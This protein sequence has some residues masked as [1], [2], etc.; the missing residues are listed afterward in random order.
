MKKIPA[1]LMLCMAV[2]SICYAAATSETL[3][4]RARPVSWYGKTAAGVVTAVKVEDDGTVVTSGGSGESV[5]T[6][7]ND[8][9]YLDGDVTITGVFEAV[10]LDVSGE[11]TFDSNVTVAAL[12]ATN[13]I[14]TGSAGSAGSLIMET[15]DGSTSELTI[16]NTDK[17]WI[18]GAEYTAGL[19]NVSDETY[20]ASVTGSLSI[21]EHLT[22]TGNFATDGVATYSGNATIAF[23]D[24]VNNAQIQMNDKL[25]IDL[26]DSGV[27]SFKNLSDGDDLNIGTDL[28]V[29]GSDIYFKGVKLN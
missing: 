3:D 2:S 10:T 4:T 8:G 26:T 29:D 17:I 15:D 21:S 20:G 25:L 24:D 11:A 1:M 16:S 7:T 13:G 14:S 27:I 12:I 18:N 23:E 9:A 6:A 5:F 28:T 19:A 22:V